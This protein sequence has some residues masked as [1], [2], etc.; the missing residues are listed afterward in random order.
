MRTRAQGT[1]ITGTLRIV[2]VDGHD[3]VRTA[4]VN[5]LQHVPDAIVLAAVSDVSSAVEQLAY[6][7]A[8]L[9]LFEPRTVLRTEPPPLRSLVAT[10]VPVVIWTSSLNEDEVESYMHA[11]AVAVLLKDANVPHLV[12]TLAAII[13]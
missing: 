1:T 2:L 10:G 8:D 5:R 9:I 3:R 12:A 11:G 13:A 7:K 4:L 6:I